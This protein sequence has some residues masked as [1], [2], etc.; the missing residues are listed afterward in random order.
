VQI[1]FQVRREHWDCHCEYGERR[2]EQLYGGYEVDGCGAC[3]D[4]S[5]SGLGEQNF[6]LV[7]PDSQKNLNALMV[8]YHGKL[9]TLGVQRKD[10]SRPEGGDGA[11]DAG[12][13]FEKLDH[14]TDCVEAGFV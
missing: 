13:S 14:F 8:M 9:L 2:C 1:H 12:D 5:D 3:Y 6:L 4:G 10:E 11:G 7:R